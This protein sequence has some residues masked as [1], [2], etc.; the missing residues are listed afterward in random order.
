MDLMKGKCF[1]YES[2]GIHVAFEGELPLRKALERHPL[3]GQSAVSHFTIVVML[4]VLQAS[5]QPKVG[6]LNA[7]GRSIFCCCYQAV[8][9]GQV[10]MHKLVQKMQS[11]TWH[12]YSIEVCSELS[13]GT[14][15]PLN[16]MKNIGKSPPRTKEILTS[17][18]LKENY[19]YIMWKE[20]W[21]NS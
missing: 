8:P 15:L 11:N 3:D 2:G 4:C 19:A 20:N 10:A 18:Y 9:C 13:R 16:L 5:S 17:S 6:H 14:S 21:Q 12:H 7:A 1:S